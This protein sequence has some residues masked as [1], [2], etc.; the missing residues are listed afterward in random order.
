M[1]KVL[2]EKYNFVRSGNRLI[3]TCVAPAAKC[4]LVPYFDA[5]ENISAHHA[6][7]SDNI[8]VCS[9]H[10]RANPKTA[11]DCMPAVETLALKMCQTC[12]KERVK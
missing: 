2:E 9:L 4:Q 10:L 8:A 7:T 3:V 12:Q 1:V 5:F 11:N 6:Q